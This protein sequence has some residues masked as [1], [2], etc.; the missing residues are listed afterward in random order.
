VHESKRRG[1]SDFFL[2]FDRYG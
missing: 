1:F 2:D